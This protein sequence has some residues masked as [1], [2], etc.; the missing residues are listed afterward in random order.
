MRVT[1]AGTV[2]LHPG[3]VTRKLA[4]SVPVVRQPGDAKTSVHM[5][6]I[7]RKIIPAVG[8]GHGVL[9]GA[10][11]GPVWPETL[12]CPDGVSISGQQSLVGDSP[13]RSTVGEGK[14]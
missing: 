1:P 6:S 10:R 2:P 5:S 14:T 9:S 13:V 4:A 7:G 3:G 8:V 12:F 11:G